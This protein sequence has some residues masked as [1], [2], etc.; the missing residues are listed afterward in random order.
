MCKG[1]QI[2]GFEAKWTFH[3]FYPTIPNGLNRRLKKW[4]VVLPQIQHVPVIH[5]HTNWFY[6]EILKICCRN[7]DIERTFQTEC[8]FSTLVMWYSDK[9]TLV[10]KCV[11]A[12]IP[13]HYW[14]LCLF[15]II[16]LVY[17]IWIFLTCF[18]AVYCSLFCYW[19]RAK[20]LLAVLRF[21]YS[22]TLYNILIVS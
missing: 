19:T 7:T 9:F 8:G 16:S 17:F 1:F 10:S 5:Q 3:F 2:F 14:Q 6:R 20:F 4:E 22:L 12:S 11:S 18:A 21:V 15:Q 13:F